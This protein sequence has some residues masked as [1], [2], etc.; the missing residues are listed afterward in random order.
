M[1]MI[2]IMFNSVWLFLYVD[3][4]KY[5]IMTHVQVNADTAVDLL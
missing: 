5:S 3:K 2:Y 1:Y 4:N